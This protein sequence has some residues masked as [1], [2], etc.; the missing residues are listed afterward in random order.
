MNSAI[1]DCAALALY[2]F[3]AVCFGA[4][5]FLHAPA[6]PAV[7]GGSGKP[8]P[9]LGLARPL[10]ILGA[11]IQI[12]ATGVWCVTT[13]LSP[14]AS[15]FG[16]L[17]VLALAIAILVAL[18]DLR[19]R[20]PAIGA[21]AMAVA[22]VVLSLALAR[23]SSRAARTPLL[24]GSLVSLHVMAILASFA[25]FVLAFGCAVLYLAENRLLKRHAAIAR[26]RRLPPLETLDF[27]A[28]RSVAYAVPLLTLGIAL[29]LTGT[30]RAGSQLSPRAFLVDPHTITAAITWSLYVFY[31]AARQLAGWRGV[32]LQY[33]LV[34]GLLLVLA[35][36]AVPTTTHRFNQAR[37]ADGRDAAR[38]A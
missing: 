23:A 6:A 21:V 30:F 12:A 32:R 2:V 29:G 18:L 3:A 8:A 25:L 17:A 9:L 14:F 11:L 1:M 26:W 13:R 19:M 5:F 37:P 16:T 10:L 28:Y 7:P 4:G 34:A 15:E 33:V 38:R 22:S 31:I 27:V 35:V 36:Y 24:H 20:V